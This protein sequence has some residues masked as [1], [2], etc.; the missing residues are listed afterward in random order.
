ML[1]NARLAARRGT[2]GAT[3]TPIPATVAWRVYFEPFRRLVLLTALINAF[4]LFQN[5]ERAK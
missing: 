3:S 4:L 1:T 2:R 5:F